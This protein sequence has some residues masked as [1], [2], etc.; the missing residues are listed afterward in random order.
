MFAR[1][2]GD[3]NPKYYEE[4]DENVIA[5]PTFIQSSA[6]FDPDYFLRPKIGGD[7]WFGSGKEELKNQAAEVLKRFIEASE[8]KAAA[9]S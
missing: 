5:P 1:S 8:K 7:N 3:A 9:N 2:I 6:Q 4:K